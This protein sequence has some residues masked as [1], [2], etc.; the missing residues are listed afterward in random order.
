[1]D[2]TAR[3]LGSLLSLAIAALAFPAQATTN[4]PAEGVVATSPAP[5]EGAVLRFDPPTL[6]LGEMLAGQRKTAVLTV[7]NVGNAPVTIASMKGAVAARRWGPIPRTC[8][9]PVRRSAST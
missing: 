4:P 2:S 5:A 7:T 3:R 1:M 6:D 9:Q 8:L